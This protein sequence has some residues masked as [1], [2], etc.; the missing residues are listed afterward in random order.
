MDL[1]GIALA[2][3][4]AI[5]LLFFLFRGGKKDPTTPTP[6]PTPMPT[7]LKDLPPEVFPPFLVGGL[8]WAGQFVIDLRHRLHGCDSSGAPI[9]ESGAYDPEGG[10]LKYWI[11]VTGPDKDNPGQ[12]MPYTVFDRDGVKIDGRWLPFNY[13]PVVRKNQTDLTDET[14][15]QEAV[16]YCFV[17]LGEAKP[18][19]PMKV[20]RLCPTPPTPVPVPA[21]VVVGMMTVFYKACD[22]AGRSRS[23]SIQAPVTATGC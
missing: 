5:G 10:L 8:D 7:P 11:E 1:S 17:G 13:F 15:E 4:A 22:A 20:T 3:M 9:H 12:D 2:V 21:P 6:L 14:M 18:P 19:F 16:V 23:A